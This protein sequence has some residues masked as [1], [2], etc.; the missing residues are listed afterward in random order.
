VVVLQGENEAELLDPGL[1]R[2]PQL[3]GA[4]RLLPGALEFDVEGVVV[5][6]HRRASERDDT[7]RALAL[8]AHHLPMVAHHE[9]E[10]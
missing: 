10:R 5:G 1:A 9:S 6:V 2:S 7:H 3:D 4:V 8:V